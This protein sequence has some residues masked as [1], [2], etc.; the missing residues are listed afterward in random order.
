MA[1]LKNHALTLRYHPES[2]I[3]GGGDHDELFCVPDQDEARV[4]KHLTKTIGF[5]KME[6]KLSSLK[7]QTIAGSLAYTNIKV[8]N[9]PSIFLIHA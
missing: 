5:Q 4:V 3:F 7:K 6:K 9:I 1:K 2:I 8:E